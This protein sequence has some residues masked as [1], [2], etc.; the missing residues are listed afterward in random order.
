MTS[1]LTPRLVAASL[2]FASAA[3]SAQ[4]L[5]TPEEA[6]AA[7]SAPQPP[8]TRSVPVPGAP[9]INVVLPN[10]SSPVPSP[11][12]IQVRFDAAMPASINPET[13]KV[14][15]GALRL[16][17]T[18]RILASSKVTPTGIDVPRASLPKG[19]HR[20]FIE[21]QDSAGRTG[22]RQVQFTVE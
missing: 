1:R 22:Q 14:R 17:I 19:S 5:V 9:V 21:I 4:W 7:R 18:D 20:L 10:V 11:T 8:A 15:Y 3:A 16:D 12:P 6:E 2:V 13:F